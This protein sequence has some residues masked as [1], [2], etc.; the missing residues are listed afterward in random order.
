VSSDRGVVIDF[1]GGYGDL[2]GISKNVGYMKS[3]LV[4]MGWDIRVEKIVIIG[5]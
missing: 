5:C 3:G 4:K 1:F 2:F